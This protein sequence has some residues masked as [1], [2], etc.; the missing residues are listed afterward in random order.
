MSINSNKPRMCCS[1]RLHLAFLAMLGC[2]CFYSLRVNISFSIVCMVNHT[3]ISMSPA[4]IATNESE[5]AS[6][7]GPTLPGLTEKSTSNI[8][9]DSCSAVSIK[10]AQQDG[11][12]TWTK[13][14]QGLVLG[15]TFWGYVLTNIAG[16]VAA[17]RY[18][19]K[20][21]I[22]GALF[23][24]GILTA[25]TPAAARSN[26]Y[27]IL[28]IRFLI[29]VCLGTIS[30]ALQALFVQWIPPHESSVLRNLAFAG[31]QMGYI[32]TFPASGLLCEYGFDGGWPSLFYIQASLVMMWCLPWTL[33]VTDSPLDHPHISSKERDYIADSLMG[34]VSLDRNKQSAKV[35][36]NDAFRS[37]P[38]WACIFCHMC[39]NWGEYTFLTNIP[40]YLK[41]VL[42]FDVK[43]NGLL[44]ALPYIG[45]WLIINISS[46][47]A[48]FCCRTKMMDKTKTRKLFNTIANSR[49]V[50]VGIFLSRF[51]LS[52]WRIWILA[53][54][55][56]TITAL[57]CRN[58]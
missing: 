7:I 22:L 53:F 54:W 45:F 37:R 13:E 5:N 23:F 48:D 35:P 6:T 46:H 25:V 47:L 10:Q 15:S 12:L 1:A 56:R 31:C 29:G 9:P 43:S 3:A 33:M 36:W 44:S 16:G 40:T 52:G 32:L 17:T 28:V 26:L 11:E 57:G 42:H 18:G 38:V 4:L 20:R 34:M 39:F 55:Q 21:V 27:I 8:G 51:H 14:Q 50:E 2:V 41:E 24:A 30:P 49:T 58:M 19:G